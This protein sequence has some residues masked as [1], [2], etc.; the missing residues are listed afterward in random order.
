M[1]SMTYILDCFISRLQMQMSTSYSGRF[2]M[3]I[4][5]IYFIRPSRPPPKKK[6]NKSKYSCTE[7]IYIFCVDLTPQIIRQ[8]AQKKEI[9]GKNRIDFKRIKTQ[10]CYCTLALI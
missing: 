1:K 3:H 2:K 6:K 5:V 4:N 10:V 9:K 8:I 7:S